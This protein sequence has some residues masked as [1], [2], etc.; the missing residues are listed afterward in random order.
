[1]HDNLNETAGK[2]ADIVKSY[3]VQA[4]DDRFEPE[5]RIFLEKQISAFLHASEPVR[6]VLPG[7]PCKSP[8][9]STNRSAFCRIMA[10]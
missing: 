9:L 7:F 6:F 5:G 4:Q 8:I 3:L 10:M 1:M 2:I